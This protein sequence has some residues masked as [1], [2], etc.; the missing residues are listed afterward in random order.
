MEIDVNFYPISIPGT[1]IN[2]PAIRIVGIFGTFFYSGFINPW[3]IGTIGAL[4]FVGFAGMLQYNS[5]WVKV[6]HKPN[7][8]LTQG[9]EW[10]YST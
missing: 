5:W 1:I 2:L 4:S 9:D 6:I 3:E 10:F 8:G 7:V